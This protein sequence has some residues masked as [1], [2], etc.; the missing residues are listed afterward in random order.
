MLSID[1]SVVGTHGQRDPYLVRRSDD[2]LM[3]LGTGLLDGRGGAVAAW[4]SVDTR[5]WTYKGILFTQPAGGLVETGPVWECP[6]LVQIDGRWVLLVAVQMPAAH[7]VICLQTVWFLGDLDR[8]TFIP[9]ATGVLD[10]GDVFYAPAVATHDD[11][12]LM[13]GWIQESPELR[14]AGARDFAGAL[15]T[16]RELFINDSIVGVRPAAELTAMWGTGVS[17]SEILVSPHQPAPV[18]SPGHSSFRVRVVCHPLPGT[19]A[20][21]VIGNDGHGHP[22]AAALCVNQAGTRTLQAGRVSNLASL[23]LPFSVEVP[24]SCTTIEVHADVSIVEV[25]ADGRS[26]TFRVD[27][28]LDPEPSVH[29]LARGAPVLARA[30]LAPFLGTGG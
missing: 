26:I 3:V 23:A 7:G 29:L 2:W 21:V 13:W 16:P 5:H 17:S 24:S 14:E 15:S 4:S 25:F 11:R 1:P 18:G 9:Q 19:S 22:V 20:G 12:S 6:Q 8:E 10:A 28:E 27:P 30:E